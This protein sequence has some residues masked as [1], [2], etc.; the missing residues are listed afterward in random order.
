MSMKPM[1]IVR[2]FNSLGA[3]RAQ[4]NVA[5]AEYA[6]PSLD[7]LAN[8]FCPFYRSELERMGLGDWEPQ[9]D[10]FHESQ[11]I[12]VMA[13]GE[14]VITDFKTLNEMHLRGVTLHVRD[15]VG[16]QRVVCV[17]PKGE[18]E[19]YLLRGSGQGLLCLTPDH[20]VMD[21]DGNWVAHEER[22]LHLQAQMPAMAV[23]FESIGIELAWTL[24]LFCADGYAYEKP[25]GSKYINIINTEEDYVARAHKALNQ[26]FGDVWIRP[27][28]VSDDV[29]SVRGGVEL[30]SRQHR[31]QFS[32]NKGKRGRATGAAAE[33]ARTVM[34]FFAQFYSGRD[35][36]IP[37]FV[38]NLKLEEIKA[39]L[40]GY[41]AGD[42]H[43]TQADR[44]TCESPLL[45]YQL[46][47]LYKHVLGKEARIRPYQD[48]N[49]FDVFFGDGNRSA[50]NE[51]WLTTGQAFDITVET[52]KFCIGEYEVK[53]CDDFAWQFYTQIRWAHYNTR[54]SMAEGIAVGV[55]YYMAGAR[56][57]DG[58]GGG[59]AINFAVVGEKE[60]RQII[61]I[62]PQF[63]GVED[64][65]HPVI[66]LNE[67]ERSSIWFVNM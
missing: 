25:C 44:V 33:A 27:N 1:E 18:K 34:D 48:K 19:K 28:Y 11:P 66:K 23:G 15:R 63:A 4:M 45:A 21:V 39:F 24:G 8:H 47:Y 17:L 14:F 2:M 41:Y 38:F 7:Y 29:G 16:W 6:V 54:R 62:E 32:P 55:L 40:D 35:K 13:D 58:T 10:C 52:G 46:W 3:G 61:F 53:N 20:K 57:E 67:H 26:E 30:K 9:W 50:V 59:H 49:T 43:K 65:P 36:V 51:K 64:A 60:A 42:G 31:L 37:D 5:D 56:A 12:E 22:V